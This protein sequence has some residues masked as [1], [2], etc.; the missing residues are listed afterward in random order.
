MPT[1]DIAITRIAR[2]KWILYWSTRGVQVEFHQ[3]SPL[4]LCCNKCHE[5][6]EIKCPFLRN[7]NPQANDGLVNRRRSSHQL[8]FPFPE[9]ESGKQSLVGHMVSVWAA[10]R[11][12]IGPRRTQLANLAISSAS[13]ME[14]RLLAK[15]NHQRRSNFEFW[16]IEST[17]LHRLPQ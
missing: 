15:T 8:L 4:A 17:N 2:Q 6:R 3:K 11:T 14:V 9:K 12:T 5:K 16:F 10:I 13:A 7:F 1:T